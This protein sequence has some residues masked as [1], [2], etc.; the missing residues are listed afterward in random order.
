MPVKENKPDVFK[1]GLLLRDGGNSAG[2]GG[3]DVPADSGVASGAGEASRELTKDI[4]AGNNKGKFFKIMI[5]YVYYL[6][7]SEWLS[8]MIFLSN[9]L[10][11]I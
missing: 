2:C 7:R 9:F 5:D 4:K 6:R 3:H 11:E 8:Y 1:P 10:M